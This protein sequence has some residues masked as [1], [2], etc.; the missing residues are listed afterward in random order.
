MSAIEC[1]TEGIKLMKN[2]TVWFIQQNTRNYWQKKLT[3]GFFRAQYSNWVVWTDSISF[4]QLQNSVPFS[5]NPFATNF[6]RQNQTK[7]QRG[8]SPAD[9]FHNNRGKHHDE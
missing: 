4:Q 5:Q 2:S 8:I 6:Y 9:F 7:Q 1:D 3:H